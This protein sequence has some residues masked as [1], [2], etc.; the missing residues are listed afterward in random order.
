MPN[1]AQTLGYPTTSALAEVM[2]RPGMTYRKLRVIKYRCLKD[3]KFFAKVFFKE[4]TGQKF[5]WMRHH[6]AMASALQRVAEGQLTRLAI[7]CPPGFSKTELV[8]RLFGAYVF[9]RFVRVKNFHLS[10]SA[11]LAWQ[12]SKEVQ[13]IVQSDLFQCLFPMRAK[14]DRHAARSWRTE[15]NGAMVAGSTGGQV[16]GFR[17]GR[18]EDG[19]LGYMGI[20][21]PIKPEDA[22]FVKIRTKMNNRYPNTIRSRLAR[23]DT[24]IVLI[25]QMV[26]YDDFVNYLLKGGSGE[27]WH[28]LIIPA[29]VE[30]EDPEYPEEYTHGIPIPYRAPLGYTWPLKVSGEFAEA[31]KKDA[32]T[33]ATQYQQRPTV[34]TGEIFKTDWW[35]YYTAFD[36]VQS[37]IVLEGGARVKGSYKMIYADTAMK[38]GEKNDWSCFQLWF[39]M[40]DGR[41]ALLNLE[42]E[43]YEAPELDDNFTKFCEAGEFEAHINNMGVRERKVEDKASGTGLIQAINKRKGTNWIT[44]IPRDTDK[45]SRAK[46]VAPQIAQGKVL[47]PLGVPWLPAYISEF[48]RFN[49]AMTHA[50]DDQIDPTID[51]IMDMVICDNRINY[52][53]VM[54]H[55]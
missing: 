47:L 17:A 14:V 49:S 41:I 32:I 43:K 5:I 22:I 25:M 30:E 10:Y 45:V 19:F 11:D 44:G 15:E 6:D 13:E 27:M 4:R 37:E 50:H 7:S 35:D 36:P 52:S 42:R 16:T 23:P 1:V 26:H 38:T 40:N 12:T 48:Q 8:M 54:K 46:S 55:G 33:W 53:E 18:L 34:D 51:A 3:F 39:K 28:H 2:S 20:D 9:A 21:D 24:P 31:L 29:E